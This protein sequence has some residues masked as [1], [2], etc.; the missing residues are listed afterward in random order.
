MSAA[1]SHPYPATPSPP[2]RPRRHV[3]PSATVMELL[4]RAQASLLYASQ[5]DQVGERY[6]LAHLAGL[7][8][9]AAVLAA[10]T[11]PARSSRPRSVWE[12]LPTLA[13]ELTEWAVFFA[14]SARQRAAVER[15][16]RVLPAREADDLVR[17]AGGV[18]PP[19]GTW[20]HVYAVDLARQAQAFIEVVQDALGVPRTFVR[21][22]Y[23]A[24]VTPLAR[25]AGR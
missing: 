18:T 23:L 12:V 25:H 24:P 5:T 13:P 10:R 3:P 21:P 14:A 16:D 2:L 19:G 7:R 20:L 1:P 17:Q 9:A 22:D 8:A 15:G 4:D 11:T 6:V